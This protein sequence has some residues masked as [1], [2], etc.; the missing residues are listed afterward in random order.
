MKPNEF[1]EKV[2][3]LE[4]ALNERMGEVAR[5]KTS[6]AENQE[7]S[8]IQQRIKIFLEGVNKL[9]GEEDKSELVRQADELLLELRQHRA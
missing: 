3:E 9:N 8:A 5:T 1:N 4:E 6:E 7:L 2:H